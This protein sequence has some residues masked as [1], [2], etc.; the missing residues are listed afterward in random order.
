MRRW[1]TTEENAT[2][3]ARLLLTTVMGL[4]VLARGYPK[5]SVFEGAARQALSMLGKPD[6]KRRPSART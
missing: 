3:V 6:R 4:R 1:I 2:D 5:R